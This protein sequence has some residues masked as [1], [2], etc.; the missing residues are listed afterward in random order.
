MTV[1]FAM[2]DL[3]YA[4]STAGAS[5]EKE[6]REMLR[7]AGASAVGFMVDDDADAVI[8]QFRIS[9]R[10][11]TVPVSVAAYAQAYNRSYPCGSR[12]SLEDHQ[13]KARKQAE[14]AVWAVLADW[15]KAQTAMI[16]CGFLDADTA[17]LPHIHAPDGRRI[18]DVLRSGA[19]HNLLLP[20]DSEQ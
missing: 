11:V 7:A 1:I 10:Q 6:I 8:C 3:P 13:R 5:R 2:S 18:A 15:I 12:T 4:S 19:G 9:G 14:T 16:L 20:K 17:F